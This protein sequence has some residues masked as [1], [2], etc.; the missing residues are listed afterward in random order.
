MNPRVTAEATLDVFR[1]FLPTA[2]DPPKFVSSER[3]TSEPSV[4]DF[5]PDAGALEIES[6]MAE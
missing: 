5:E 1:K 4:S 3:R 6:R 2:A